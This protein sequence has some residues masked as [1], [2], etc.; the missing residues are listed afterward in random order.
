MCVWVNS[1]NN[2]D[3]NTTAGEA[4]AAV[5]QPHSSPEL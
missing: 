1:Y 2:I 4:A 5:A 3:N